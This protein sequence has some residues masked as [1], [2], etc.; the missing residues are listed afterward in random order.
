MKT[1]NNILFFI[2]VIT[3]SCKKSSTDNTPPN[4]T[5]TPTSIKNY[6]YPLPYYPAYPGSYWK[7]KLINQGQITYKVDSVSLDYVPCSFLKERNPNYYSDTIFVPRDV[8]LGYI[9]GYMKLM[10]SG[11]WS[12]HWTYNWCTFFFQDYGVSLPDGF[13]EPHQGI[14]NRVYYTVYDKQK[15]FAV[16]NIIY[17][18][19]VV[20]CGTPYIGGSYN[21]S[22]IWKYFSKNVGLVATYNIDTNRIDTSSR[23]ILIDYHINK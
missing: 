1:I 23:M 17:D 16:E 22:K 14:D 6:V 9:N 5:P 19:V 7:Y 21:F 2:L 8:N 10:H 3:F 15:N 18:S 12:L 4:P 20:L 13:Y 11:T